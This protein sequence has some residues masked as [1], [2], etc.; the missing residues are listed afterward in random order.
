MFWLIP[1]VTCKK[2]LIQMEVKF[3]FGNKLPPGSGLVSNQQTSVCSDVKKRSL[4]GDGCKKDAREVF[5]VSKAFFFKR[6]VG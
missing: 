3:R 6:R 2:T 5:R 1:Y 4:S